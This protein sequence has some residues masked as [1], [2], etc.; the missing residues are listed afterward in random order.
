M[1]SMITVTID[2]KRADV[3]PGT[4]VLEAARGLG[5]HI[6]TLCFVEGLEPSS[7]CFMCAVQVEGRPNL[8]P[9]CALPVADGM[10]VTTDSDDI[11]GARKMALE[12]LLSDHAGDCVAPCRARCPAGLDIAG[13]VYELASGNN[14]RSLEVILDQLALP[15]SLGRICPRLC[16]EGCRRCDLD[17]G[18]AIAALHRYPADRDREEA[19]PFVP[20]RTR[21]TGKSVAI[22][23]AG[24]AGLAAA[25]YLLQKGHACT[26]YDAQPEPGGMLRYGIPAYRLPK[27]ALGAEIETIRKLGARFQMSSAWGRDFT[28]TE[29]GRKHDAVFVAIGAWRSQSLRCDGEHLA[30][31]GIELLENVAKN[32]APSLGDDVIVVGGGNTAMDSS[33]TAVRLGAKDVRVLY[34]RSRQEMPCLMEEVEAAELEGVVID[35]L[36]APIR[37]EKTNGGSLTLTCQ[38]MKLGEPDDSGRRRP[39]AE[40]G[41]EFTI[42]CTAV[43]AAIGQSVDRSLPEREGLETTAWGIA[44]DPKTLATNLPGVFAG[45]DAVLGADLAVRAVAAGRIAAVSIDQYLT[46][47]PVTGPEEM[48]K[49]EMR[50]VSE[51]ERA[52]LFREIEKSPR[53][54]IETIDINRRRT[55]FDEVDAGL[56]EI[57]VAKE[58]RRCMTCGCRKE[59]NCLMRRWSTEYGVDPYRFTGERR[60]FSQDVTHPDVIYEPGKCIMCDACVRIAAEAGEELG[61]ATIGRGF[62]VAMGVPFGEPLSEGLKQA[63]R[64]AAEKCPTGALALRTGRSCDLGACDSCPSFSSE[65]FEI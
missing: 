50:A 48:T 38:R 56:S 24:P 43:I 58:S 1:I 20:P 12:L 60:R 32:R 52:A 15:G 34:R 46:G 8:S 41:T 2:G 5:I 14:R 42:E 53:P 6:P 18:L 21:P 17:E 27:D 31:S 36:V 37:L 39:V 23:G 51:D 10:V 62:T 55:T 29:L 19:E 26:L 47:Q 22:I 63:A 16:E 40:P 4:T 11:R 59:D 54:R 3:E 65:S 33:R 61:V 64:R 57:D 49:V 25:F 13:F 9:A 7:S 28:F 44:T 30:L 45:G 35:Y